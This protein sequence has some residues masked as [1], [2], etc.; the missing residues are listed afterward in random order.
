[1]NRSFPESI[2][3]QPIV[4]YI[5][6]SDYAVRQPG[7]T[8]LNRKLLDYLLV[9][10]QEGECR[11]HVDGKD[12]PLTSGDICLIQP[13]SLTRLE[14]MTDTI[15]PY[16]HLDLFYNSAREESFP[17]RAGQIDLAPY[18]HLLQPRLND[19]PGV[20][21]PVRLKPSKPIL[22]RDTMLQMIANWLGQDPL[23]ALKAQ[24]FATELVLAILEDHIE[25]RALETNAMPSLNWITSFFSLHI[26]D[27]HTVENM[28]ERAQISPEQNRRAQV[29]TPVT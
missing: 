21:V 7:W 29:C 22:F 17:T 11:F 13:G 4:P 3:D 24:H 27:P 10:V 19:L 2:K 28:A 9:Y 18:M 12:Y 14:G 23:G 16:A 8:A 15:T 1:M 25:Q 6:E 26:T 5:R 20:D